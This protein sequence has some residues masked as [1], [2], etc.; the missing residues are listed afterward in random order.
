MRKQSRKNHSKNTAK[1]KNP[2]SGSSGKSRSSE[3]D[4]TVSYLSM[5]SLDFLNIVTRASESGCSHFYLILRD[6]TNFAHVKRISC[7][8]TFPIPVTVANSSKW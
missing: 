2:L 3:N 1:Q 6:P 5:T 4:K 8:V 7:G